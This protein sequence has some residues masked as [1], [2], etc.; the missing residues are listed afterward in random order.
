ME[1]LAMAAPVPIFPMV[2]EASCQSQQLEAD[3][4]E[5]RG[6]PPEKAIT[7]C[8]RF[9]RGVFNIGADRLVQEALHLIARASG[10]GEV[11]IDATRLPNTPIAP[12]VAT[13]SLAHSLLHP[14][15]PLREV[16]NQNA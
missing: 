7:I 5:E 6:F 3:T 10:D 9:L 11:E 2:P 12:C 15:E 14:L 4:V 13:Q 16:A 1:E 8:R